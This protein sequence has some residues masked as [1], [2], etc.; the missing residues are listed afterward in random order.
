MFSHLKCVWAN[1][2]AAKNT[3]FLR[4]Y[5]LD[6]LMSSL[7]SFSG[8]T[9]VKLYDPDASEKFPFVLARRENFPSVLI[10][11]FSHRCRR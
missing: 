3:H 4:G 9:L 11:S 1:I 6:L 2:F 5:E 10:P 8:I 7:F